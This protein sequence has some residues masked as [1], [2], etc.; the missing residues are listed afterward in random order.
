[1]AAI[2]GQL[3]KKRQMAAVQGPVAI[4]VPSQPL[5]ISKA[6]QK[7]SVLDVWGVQD[8]SGRNNQLRSL[9]SCDAAQAHQKVS[10]PT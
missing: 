8:F 2:V 3:A 6:G 5:T 4:L 7:M 1:M 9:R 10:T